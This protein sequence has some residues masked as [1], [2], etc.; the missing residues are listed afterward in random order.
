MVFNGTVVIP[1]RIEKRRLCKSLGRGGGWANKV[2]YGKCAT[3]GLILKRQ[4]YVKLL[5]SFVVNVVVLF[6]CLCFVFICLFFFVVV[7]FVLFCFALQLVCYVF[8]IK[9][10]GEFNLSTLSWYLGIKHSPRNHGCNFLQQPNP[11]FLHPL[12]KFLRI[13][14]QRVPLRKIP[15]TRFS[16]PTFF[17]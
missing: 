8:P 5:C 6:C 9:V 10:P 16:H 15:S 2:H 13:H 14:F 4:Q 1:R 11:Q 3:A 17:L 12:S 7:C